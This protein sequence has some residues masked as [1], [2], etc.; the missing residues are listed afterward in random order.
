VFRISLSS[1]VASNSWPGLSKNV[2]PKINE[3]LE[4]SNQHALIRLPKATINQFLVKLPWEKML[5]THFKIFRPSDKIVVLKAPFLTSDN[6]IR[7]H[8]YVRSPMG[9]ITALV[10]PMIK[11]LAQVFFPDTEDDDLNRL[12][13]AAEPA[14]YTQSKDLPLLQFAFSFL[15]FRNIFGY[16]AAIEGRIGLHSRLM[17]GEAGDRKFAV[18]FTHVRLADTEGPGLVESVIRSQ[19]DRP[20]HLL[21][22]F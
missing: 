22:Y 21:Q 11:L 7:F 10:S 9:K 8:V 14:S 6:E 13:D 2:N 12:F 1:N 20:V 3:T 16:Q 18:D 19:S 17:E 15:D 5:R 4:T